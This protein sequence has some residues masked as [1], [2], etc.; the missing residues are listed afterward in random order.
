MTG[1]PRGRN[2]VETI[3]FQISQV[4]PQ[5]VLPLHQQITPD[6]LRSL[7]KKHPVATLHELCEI[8]EKQQGVIMSTT[9][10]CKLVKRYHILR[11]HSHHQVPVY[12]SV[13]A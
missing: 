7:I 6:N 4:L 9:A 13:A 10:M 1:D 5:P 2:S 3:P 12:P 11:R 8:V